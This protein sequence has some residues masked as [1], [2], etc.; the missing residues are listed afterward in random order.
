MYTI[1]DVNADAPV[2]HGRPWPTADGFEP[3]GLDPNLMLLEEITESTPEYDPLTHTVVTGDW[4]YD[5][6]A[7]TATR[8]KTLVE[9]TLADVKRDKNALID[10][11]TRELI[12]AGF[13]HDGH[14]FSL[15]D[16]A[17][18]NIVGLKTPIDAGWVTFPHAM[19]TTDDN[20]PEY[21]LADVAAYTAVYAA[22]VGTVKAHTDS[23]RTLKK[24]VAAAETIADVAAVVD[25]R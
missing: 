17:Q 22:A 14:H 11:R 19:S 15:S 23:G 25:E 8:S 18:M 24:A 4:V 16:Q 5:L 2:V 7:K 3:P 1:Y 12:G 20:D 10:A 9:R 21:V 13:T 6:D